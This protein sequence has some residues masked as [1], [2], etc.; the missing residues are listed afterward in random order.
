MSFDRQNICVTTGGLCDFG[1]A[2]M[3]WRFFGR[4]FLAGSGDRFS[5]AARRGAGAIWQAECICYNG[6]AM[7]F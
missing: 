5:R 2:G 1:G 4:R 7:R 3:T 6:W